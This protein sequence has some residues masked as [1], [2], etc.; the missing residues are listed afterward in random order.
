MSFWSPEYSSLNQE[1]EETERAFLQAE[2]R[3]TLTNI[4]FLLHFSLV[5]LL[6]GFI[7]A[8]FSNKVGQKKKLFLHESWKILSANKQK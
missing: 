6:C 2:T 5:F 4:F 7:L 8:S 3:A 1:G